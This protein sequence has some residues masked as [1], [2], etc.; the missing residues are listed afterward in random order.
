MAPRG[1]AK[2]LVMGLC[3]VLLMAS[4]M[5][6]GAAIFA[7]IQGQPYGVWYGLGLPGLLGLTIVGPLSFVIAHRY[8]QA[9]TQRLEAQDL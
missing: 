6:L 4:C 5:L 7:L 9:E 1:K 2:G 3:V 8:R